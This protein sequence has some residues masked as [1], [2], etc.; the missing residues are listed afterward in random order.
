MKETKADHIPLNLEVGE[1]E[2]DSEEIRAKLLSW[3]FDNYYKIDTRIYE[4]YID[5]SIPRRLNEMNSPLICIRHWDKDFVKGLIARSKERHL[6]LME[7]KSLSLEAS[8]VKSI[9]T[10]YNRKNEDPLLKDISEDLTHSS[11]WFHT[12]PHKHW[13]CRLYDPKNGPLQ[14]FQSLRCTLPSRSTVPSIS[15]IFFWCVSGLEE[16]LM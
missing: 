10:L 6:S 5:P 14:P 7:D 11:V 3:S 13:L 12:N 9:S 15:Y 8:I 16:T 4:K 2:K 1:F